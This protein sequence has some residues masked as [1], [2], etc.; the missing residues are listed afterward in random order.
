MVTKGG[1]LNHFFLAHFI[2]VISELKVKHRPMGMVEKR[3]FPFAD[4]P[5]IGMFSASLLSSNFLPLLTLSYD[6]QCKRI[7]RMSTLSQY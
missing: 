5:S 1:P 7:K 3:V 4:A 6:M 2:T